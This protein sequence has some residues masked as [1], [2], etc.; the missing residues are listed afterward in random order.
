MTLSFLLIGIFSFAQ[1]GD[2]SYS[3]TLQVTIEQGS[4]TFDLS[5]AGTSISIIADQN[6][7][8]VA[9]YCFQAG[10]ETTLFVISGTTGTST[11][12]SSDGR[13]L[14]LITDGQPM[15]A[16]AGRQKNRRVEM[17]VVFE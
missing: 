3:E 9:G 10:E 15:A 13:I 2:S 16:E 14:I 4:N 11:L 12:V 7:I 5:M 1:T 17:E 6:L 8:P